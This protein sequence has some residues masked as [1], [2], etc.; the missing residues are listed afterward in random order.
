MPKESVKTKKQ[1]TGNKPGRLT[2]KNKAVVSKQKANNL[3]VSIYNL[4]GTKSG[5]MQLPEEI[6]GGKVNKP[7]LAQAIRVYMNNLK[8][9]FGSTKTR[10]EVKYSTKKIRAQKGT[11]GAR[12]GS[13]GAPIFVGGGIAL[14]PKFR[15]IRLFLPRKMKQAALK[16]A[17]VTKID[18]EEVLGVADLKKATG[19]TKQM[20]N[21]MQKIGKKDI[22][23][24][25]D[26][27]VENLKR[28]VRNL[29]G[30]DT[31]TT[32]ELNAYEVI[33]HQTLILT[34]EAVKKLESRLKNKA[35]E[36]E[37]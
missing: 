9:H 17:L 25:T 8:A 21:F 13:L 29:E 5:T 37:V 28:A 34:R 35:E 15:R 12:H 16:S 2:T 30:F 14:G 27:V 4:D 36:V 19:K 7:L 24:I 18:A 33:A 31:L 1:T 22:L 26:G 3:S 10:S 6:F 23:L 20:Q 11:G 32:D